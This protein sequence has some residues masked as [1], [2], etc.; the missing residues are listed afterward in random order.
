MKYTQKSTAAKH[1]MILQASSGFTAVVL[2]LLLD[3][4]ARVTDSH[5]WQQQEEEQVCTIIILG[6]LGT[7][8]VMRLVKCVT[9]YTCKKHQFFKSKQMTKNYPTGN[10]I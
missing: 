10:K 5:S 9:M 8:H 2:S 6:G 4:H 7:C 1:S 3:T